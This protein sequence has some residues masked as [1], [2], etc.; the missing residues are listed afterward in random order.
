METIV[1]LKMLHVNLQGPPLDGQVVFQ[2]FNDKF[3]LLIVLSMYYILSSNDLHHTAGSAVIMDGSSYI[4]FE[5]WSNAS[6]FISDL[7]NYS[8]VYPC[9]ESDSPGDVIAGLPT[10]SGSAREL[11]DNLTCSYAW[12]TSGRSVRDNCLT[13]LGDQATPVQA[14]LAGLYDKSTV[15]E[16]YEFQY[17]CSTLLSWPEGLMDD[18]HMEQSRSLNTFLSSDDAYGSFFPT[19]SLKNWVQDSAHFSTQLQMSN[20]L[21]LQSRKFFVYLIT[22]DLNEDG[23]FY[24]RIRVTFTFAV[25]G[26]ATVSLDTTFSPMI[27]FSYGTNGHDWVSIIIGTDLPVTHHQT[28]IYVFLQLFRDIYVWECILLL[29][30]VGFT[31]REIF[32]LIMLGWKKRRLNTVQPVEHVSGRS[33]SNKS[34]EITQEL[35]NATVPPLQIESDKNSDLN[36]DVVASDFNRNKSREDDVGGCEVEVKKPNE[37]RTI[38]NSSSIGK[39][40]FNNNGEDDWDEL[41]QL[42]EDAIPDKSIVANFLDWATV[43][44]ICSLLGLRFDYIRTSRRLHE[45]FLDLSEEHSFSD[46]MARIMNGFD[47]LNGLVETQRLLLMMVMFVGMTQFFRYLSFDSRLGIVAET[48]LHSAADLLPVLFIFVIILVG[49]SVL[50][51]AIFGQEVESWSTVGGS[52]L[53]LMIFIVG[54]YGSYFESE[55]EHSHTHCYCLL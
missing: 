8:T 4:A 12:I 50:G 35:K 7:H 48:I 34:I 16:L 38:S 55:Y 3:Q 18:V 9:Y 20:A 29:L 42:V 28:H 51:S 37:Y 2:D 22:R 45:Y 27:D 19:S 10:F 53:N 39:I 25:E 47:N 44:I 33:S 32:Q 23:L 24:A 31:I 52:M 30:F 41:E 15:S 1:L 40:D 11:A 46:G 6:L 54:E 26:A 5:K 43:G 17:G 49:Y 13:E 36:P 14:Y 21:D